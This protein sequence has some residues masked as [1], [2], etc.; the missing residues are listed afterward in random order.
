MLFTKK[1]GQINFNSKYTTE[2]FNAFINNR[3]FI[4][5]NPNRNNVKRLKESVLK[6]DG[7]KCFYTG[8]KMSEKQMT[9]EHLVPLSKGGTNN[10]HNL[11]LCTEESNKKMGDKNAR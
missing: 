8:A 1:D 3:K 2:I 5:K 4:K 9:L 6:R 11:V 7:N 10:L